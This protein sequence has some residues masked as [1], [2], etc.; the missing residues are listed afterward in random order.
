MVLGD[1]LIIPKYEFDYLKYR[2]SGHSMRQGCSILPD[3]KR[4]VE[5][6]CKDL[7]L[8]ANAKPLRDSI[9]IQKRREGPTK[10]FRVQQI[11]IKRWQVGIRFSAT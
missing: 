10:D 9:I 4:S 6:L 3:S 2:R 1:K 11:E 5:D 8:R 7:P